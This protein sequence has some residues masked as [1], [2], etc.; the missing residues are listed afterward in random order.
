M[1]VLFWGTAEFALPALIALESEGHAVVGV[2]TQP[3]RPAGRGRKT[4]ASPVKDLAEDEGY[5]V[6]QP[7]RPWGEDF[8]AKIT[9][10]DPDISVVA[11]YGHIL[12]EE[13][14]KIPEHGSINIHASYLPEL[15]GAAP[16]SWAIIR[17]YDVT[18]VSIIR[19]V[20][21]MD[22]G[23]VLFQAHEPIYPRDSAATLTARLSEIGAELLIEVL[24]LLEAGD[25]QETE[26]DHE[27]ATFAPKVDRGLAR[28]RWDRTAEEVSNLIRGMDAAPGAWSLLDGEP[29]KLFRP[30]LAGSAAAHEPDA[31]PGTVLVADPAEGLWVACGRGRV[32]VTEVQPPGR[33]RMPAAD[34]LRGR[35]VTVGQ[36]FE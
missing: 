12:K 35:A 20:K 33:R 8:L 16:V 36:R 14:L 30:E 5:V 23:P 7:E 27:R 32:N 10:L 15:R 31:E 1:K 21:E 26:Q 29:V 24:A 3:D 9:A 11:A 18:G 13:V 17:G 6:L 28:V 2:V 19:M 25:V 34:W 4:K 22:A